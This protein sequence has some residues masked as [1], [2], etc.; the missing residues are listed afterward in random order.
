VIQSGG[1]EF[2]VWVL[3]AS[4]GDARSIGMGS[5]VRVTGVVSIKMSG[6]KPSGFELLGRSGADIFVVQSAGWWNDRRVILV[7]TVLTGSV[8]LLLSYVFLLRR[9]VGRQT[10]TIR[11]RLKQEEELKEQ[12]RQSQR[13]ESVGRLAGGIAHDFNNIMTVVM[14]HIE[15][16]GHELQGH[17]DLMESVDEIR[18]AA[19][20]ASG[21]TRQLL[22]FGR[23]ARL[24]PEVID[25][26]V[27]IQEMASLFARVLGGDIE[28]KARP[29]DETVTILA[30][31]RQLEQALLNLAVN[32]RDAMPDGGRLT[33]AADRREDDRGRALGVVTV[34]DTGTGIPADVQPHI[35]D[36]F[37][38]TKEVGQGSGLGLAMIYGFMQQTGGS[39]HFESADG[40]GTLFELSFPLHLRAALDD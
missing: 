16:L 7:A 21:V 6:D 32:A 35:F 11:E 20:R 9:Q 18:S 30:D 23:R 31:R 19:D 39:V 38:T 5:R 12:Y 15:V 25:L 2:P 13:M 22:A 34:R 24:Q 14:G 33:L 40:A 3:N 28:T 8:V 26:N 10:A 17:P 37:F 4:A 27:T 1:S 29:C 36:P